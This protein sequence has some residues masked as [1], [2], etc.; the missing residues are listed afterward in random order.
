LGDTFS[1]PKNE[2]GLNGHI[3]DDH[4]IEG[5]MKSMVPDAIKERL[6]EKELS[7]QNARMSLHFRNYLKK[8]SKTPAT[9]T[10]VWRTRF[11]PSMTSRPCGRW[12]RNRL[13]TTFPNPQPPGMIHKAQNNRQPY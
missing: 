9:S 3:E 6:R 11:I 12:G 13:P 7:A 10:I 8:S 5:I 4:V 1:L 2:L